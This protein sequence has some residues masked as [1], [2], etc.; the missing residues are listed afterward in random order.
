M[1]SNSTLSPMSESNKQTLISRLYSQFFYLFQKTPTI[2]MEGT[3]VPYHV[4][5]A[6]CVPEKLI[7]DT[8]LT[9]SSVDILKYCLILQL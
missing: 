2:P 6:I 9:A 7:W 1:G 5:T 3:K 8:P 4:I